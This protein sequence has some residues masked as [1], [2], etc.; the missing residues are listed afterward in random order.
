MQQNTAMHPVWCQDRVMEK[1]N[2]SFEFYHWFNAWNQQILIL[3]RV[4]YRNKGPTDRQT[5]Q[6]SCLLLQYQG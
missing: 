4:T 6:D 3:A 1:H 5:F 2:Q